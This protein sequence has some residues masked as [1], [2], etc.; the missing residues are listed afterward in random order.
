[1]EGREPGYRLRSKTKGEDDRAVAVYGTFPC[2]PKAATL[3]EELLR[4][5]IE[6]VHG[7][8]TPSRMLA[9]V[10]GGFSKPGEVVESPF[11]CSVNAMIII[12]NETDPVG[13]W[14]MERV[15]V[16][17][18]HKRAFGITPNV[19]SHVLVGAD[20]DDTGTRNRAFVRNTN[21]VPK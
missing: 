2:D 18:D 14:G 17:A 11:F 20:S 10:W 8:D 7:P 21:F 3:T 12:R 19:T 15:N 1:M 16:V 9:Y 5:V 13:D 4:P 6:L